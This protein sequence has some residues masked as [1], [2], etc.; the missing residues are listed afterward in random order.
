VNEFHAYRADKA[1]IT[2]LARELEVKAK[3]IID[4]LPG[5]GITE[6]K[7]HSSS[8]PVEV[9]EKI[10]KILLAES[11]GQRIRRLLTSPEVTGSSGPQSI[12]SLPGD[13]SV[14]LRLPKKFTFHRGFV[15]FD[16]VLGC[17]NWSLRE[18]PVVVDL[19]TCESANYQ[20]L[21]LLIQYA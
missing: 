21:A 17:F 4:L 2:E 12:K 8:I 5:Y 13:S 3:A 11:I 1:R 16:Y 7:T 18:V 10:R 14:T 9:A 15:D 20:A 6:K 19:T